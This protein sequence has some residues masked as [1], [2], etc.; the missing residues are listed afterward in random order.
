MF[1]S[2]F[3]TCFLLCL[4]F[5]SVWLFFPSRDSCCWHVLLFLV[6]FHHAF[7]YSFH[8]YPFLQKDLGLCGPNNVD[9]IK[10][11]LDPICLDLSKPFCWRIVFYD[12]S[13]FCSKSVFCGKSVF[14]YR[15]LSLA[16]LS[17]DLSCSSVFLVG[18]AFHWAFFLM[19]FWIW[20]H[21]I[22]HQH[23]PPTHTHIWI[24]YKVD[25]KSDD[26][27]FI[28]CKGRCRRP[29]P[30][31]IDMGWSS[32]PMQFICRGGLLRS[33]FLVLVVLIGG[34]KGKA[35]YETIVKRRLVE[36]TRYMIQAF[37]PRLFEGQMFL[38]WQGSWVTQCRNP[39]SPFSL[40]FYDPFLG[41]SF[42]PYIVAGITYLPSTWRVVDPFI[43]TCPIAT[44]LVVVE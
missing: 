3:F 19:G 6:S 43:D 15:L 36:R 1:L 2:Y 21:K 13:I 39:F 35:I 44:L 32:S 8:T 10:R 24:I 28:Y 31:R 34:F 30:I 23:P 11:V 4:S 14:C 42:L 7:S 33:T 26:F 20:I 37:S 18:L 16:L 38:W 41:G 27:G 5:P 25:Q 22:G 29:S 9:W 40:S 17:L 12:R